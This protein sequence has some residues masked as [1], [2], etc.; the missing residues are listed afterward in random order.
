MINGII[1]PT[2]NGI[3]YTVIGGQPYTVDTGGLRQAE[4]SGQWPLLNRWHAVGRLS[5]SF[6]DNRIL[7]SIAGIEYNQNCWTLRLVAQRFAT[8]TQQYNTGFFVQL[9]LNDLVQVGSD[10]LTLLKQSVPGYTKT[11]GNPADASPQNLR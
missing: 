9:E 10:P 2:I 6:P 3:P 4:V 5:Y 8:A 11:N 1:Y 7:D